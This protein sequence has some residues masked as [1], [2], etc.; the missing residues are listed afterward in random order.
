MFIALIFVGACD[1]ETETPKLTQ[2]FNKKF[3]VLKDY[4]G[5]FAFQG[6]ELYLYVNTQNWAN[7]RG[8]LMVRSSQIFSTSSES[9]PNFLIWGYNRG[10]GSLRER[11]KAYLKKKEPTSKENQ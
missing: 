4:P 5:G 7:F 8:D 9:D 2:D 3:G 1:H 6:G 11:T 10:K